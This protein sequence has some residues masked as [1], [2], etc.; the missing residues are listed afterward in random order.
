M[1]Y[2]YTNAGTSDITSGA[3]AGRVGIGTGSPAVT[4]DVVGDVRA[5]GDDGWSST[6][7]KG[8]V[9]LGDENHGIEGIW[10]K[11]VHI[12]TLHGGDCIYMLQE[13]GKIGIGTSSPASGVHI[14]KDLGN[15]GGFGDDQGYITLE[16]LD[17]DAPA[18][19]ANRVAI[20]TRDN[21]GKTELCARFNTG[22]IQQIAIQP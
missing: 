15:Y 20:F 17:S 8:I 4:L 10:G 12:F 16:E 3:A 22:S 6:G 5:R 13:S 14:A 19:A 18:P 11:G 7:D 1:A 9:Q 21:G 2:V